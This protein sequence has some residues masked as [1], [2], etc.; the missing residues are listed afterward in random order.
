MKRNRTEV[1]YG[2]LPNKIIAYEDSDSRK[3][4]RTFAAKVTGWQ[5]KRCENIYSK[6]IVDEIIRQINYFDFTG[7]DASCFLNHNNPENFNICEPIISDG[8][9]SINCEEFPR[10]YY[11]PECHRVFSNK[12]K[13]DKCS[14]CNVFLKQLEF[15]YACECGSIQEV[16]PPYKEGI[17]YYYD[18]IYEKYQW[19]YYDKGIK[20]TV[21]MGTKCKSCG[22]YISYPS[23][24]TDNKVYIPFNIKSVNIIDK[25]MGL[26]LDSS[27][28]ANLLLI[29]RWLG[30]VS[31]EDFAK[32]IANPSKFESSNEIDQ[33]KLDSF[34][35]LVNGDEKKALE[36][37]RAAY[38]DNEISID[39]I[40]AKTKC[41]INLI[42][43]NVV[44]SSILEYFILEDTKEKLTIEDAK[45]KAKQIDSIFDE[46][47]IDSINKKAHISAAQVVFDAQI[48]SSSFGYTRMTSSQ[49]NVSDSYKSSG[50]KLRLN[51][52]KDKDKFNVF[53]FVLDTEG[54]LVEIDRIKIISWLKDNDILSKDVAIDEKNAKKWFLNNI[55]LDAIS[56]FDDIPDSDEFIFTKIVYTLLHTI[57]H[58]LIKSAGLH[59]GI[60]TNSIAEL[61]FPINSSIFI[62]CSTLEGITL[63]AL[64]TMFEENYSIFVNDAMTEYENCMFDPICSKEQNGV[65]LAC[66][67]ISEVSC[68]NF[69]KNLSRILLYGGEYK[70]SDDRIL[71]IKKGFWR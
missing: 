43:Y 11:C 26:F 8:F 41:E 48:I 32:I 44:A 6:K 10:V 39:S 54:I 31:K 67:Y 3:G 51:G 16:T 23:N 53:S 68:V 36:I 22:T 42:D 65:C 5:T 63:G 62:Y 55:H 19:Y 15:V 21:N 24:A 35:K 50:K 61:L 56:S 34:K 2:Y 14:Y 70:L 33:S 58:L 69:N 52:F 71:S 30:V 49:S 28:E 1:I 46:T 47:E 18:P 9:N 12:N 60:D 27:R 4:K 17:Q 45:T 37:Y 66:G 25:K 7:G 20:K 38:M 64:S 57:S 29:S 40:I 59:S 13:G